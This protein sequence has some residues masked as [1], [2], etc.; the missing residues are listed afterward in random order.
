MSATGLATS[1]VV[2]VVVSTKAVTVVTHVSD[3][4][5]RMHAG[6][7]GGGGSGSGGSFDQ[8]GDDGES[9]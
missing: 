3:G 6:G 1:V 8:G 7:D 5:Q 2:V 4:V 9:F